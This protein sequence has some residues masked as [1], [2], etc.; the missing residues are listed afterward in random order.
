MHLVKKKMRTL[1]FCFC[2]F[3]IGGHSTMNPCLSRNSLCKPDWPEHGSVCLWLLSTRIKRMYHHAWLSTFVV[4]SNLIL[5]PLQPRTNGLP[6]PVDWLAGELLGWSGDAPGILLP[7][8][9]HISKVLGS[10][11]DAITPSSY[12]NAG[13]PFR[14]QCLPYHPLTHYCPSLEFNLWNKTN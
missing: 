1:A 13:I 10:Q 14:F 11:A 7:L 9:S 6:F 12:I 2:C 5:L 4:G 3:E 8:F